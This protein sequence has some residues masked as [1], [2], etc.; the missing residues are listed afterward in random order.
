MIISDGVL[1]D[2]I[3]EQA[4]GSSVVLP[5]PMIE[6]PSLFLLAAEQ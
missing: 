4:P 5:G 1:E 3:V 2:S 6:F